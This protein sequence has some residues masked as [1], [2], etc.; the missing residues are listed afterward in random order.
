[1]G[2]RLYVKAAST[3]TVLLAA[4]AALLTYNSFLHSILLHHILLNFKR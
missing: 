2:S 3:T 1:M 4:Y